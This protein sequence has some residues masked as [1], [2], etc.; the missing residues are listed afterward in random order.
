MEQTWTAEQLVDGCI[1]KLMGIPV[2][3]GLIEAIAFP[4][5]QVVGDLQ[6]LKD[7]WRKQEAQNAPAPP[8][9]KDE[10]G[11]ETAEDAAEEEQADG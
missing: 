3:A 9:P 6:M 5:R 4:I 11:E 8:E 7:A 2:P 10:T 1:Q